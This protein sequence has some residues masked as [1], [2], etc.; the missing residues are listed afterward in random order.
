MKPPTFSP[1][2]YAQTASTVAAFH[3]TVNALRPDLYR[4]CASLTRT[5]WDAEDVAQETLTRVLKRLGETRSTITN[6]KGYLLR[7]ATNVW[8]DEIRRNRPELIESEEQMPAAQTDEGEQA[9][10]VSE[11]LI[12][13]IRRLA[14]RERVCV[15]LK[16]VFDLSLDDVAAAAGTS[17][18]GVKAALH[19]GRAKLREARDTA[20]ASPVARTPAPDASL[21]AQLAAAFNK[22][23]VD[24]M[25]ALLHNSCDVDLVGFHTGDDRKFAANVVGHTFGED[26]LLRAE[27]LQLHGRQVLLLWYEGTVDGKKAEVVGDVWMPAGAS[28]CCTGMRIYYFCPDLLTAIGKQL[29]VPV[30]QN[31]YRY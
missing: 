26:G 18:G 7:T 4:Y 13:L 22:R 3:E 15:L 14:P 2:Q 31:P 25:L 1:E 6:L 21:A 17:V 8:I 30:Q 23:D 29:G 5:P 28:G 24:G 11:A 27:A 20:D 12:E 10:A 9:V 19:R 16:D